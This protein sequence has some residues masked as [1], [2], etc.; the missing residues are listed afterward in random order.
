VSHREDS[1]DQRAFFAIDRGS[2]TT[3]ASIVGWAGGRWRLLGSLSM[4]APTDLEAM[5]EL[6]V[7]RFGA[8]APG[9]A[10]GLGADVAAVDSWARLTVR[11]ATPSRIAVLAATDRTVATLAPV[12]RAAGWRVEAASLETSDSLAITRL[13]LD[14]GVAAVVA[15]SSEP[16][17]ADERAG[18]GEL[19]ALVAAAAGRRPELATVLVGAFADQLP[20]FEA[21][22]DG[23]TGGALLG[24]PANA[25]DPPGEPLRELLEG[26]RA[27]EDDGRRALARGVR[28]LAD[29]LERRIEALEV[30]FGSGSR[31]VATPGAGGEPA[32]VAGRTIAEAS[33]V[34]A[35]PDDAVI[36]RVLAWSTTAL[37]RHR[38]RDRLLELALFPWGDAAGEGAIL[39]LAVAR[40]ALTRLLEL[41]PELDT[42]SEPDLVVI[43]G[44]A[45]AVAPGPAVALAVNDVLRRPGSRQLA[46]DHARVLAPL[47]AIE[48]EAE[49]RQ[50]VV[51]LTSDLLVPLGSVI[52]PQ[53]LRAG[54][55]AG[56]VTVHGA[57]GAV[58]LDLVPGSLELVDL[59]PGETAVAELRFRETVRLGTRGRR[60]AVELAG[61]LGGLLVDLRDIPL[62][63][64]ERAERRRELL[65]AWQEALWSGVTS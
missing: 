25:G 17:G 38:L 27:G 60:F 24:P 63:L 29:V 49:R 2:A 31:I 28:T 53:G 15:G 40:S 33:L 5:L 7:A 21:D 16:A 32:T 65:G 50:V 39:R 45:W 43:G 20:R 61:G 58:E 3:S 41:T 4:P 11:T 12:A 56:Q 8:V 26:L 47:G 37:D 62:R 59:P 64:P 44:G 51:D 36:D 55:T 35:V 48:D 14:P 23:R 13:V 52:M 30:G 34:P 9:L 19:G 6:L 1:R 57:S 42:T 46:L 54:R 18:L 22:A 10:D